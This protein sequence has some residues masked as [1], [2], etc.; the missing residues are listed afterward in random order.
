MR[1]ER[2]HLLPDL[3]FHD[4][5]LFAGMDFPVVAHLTPVGDVGQQLMQAAFG[6]GSAPAHVALAREALLVAPAP[7]RQLLDDGKQTPVLQIQGKN[8]PHPRRLRVVDH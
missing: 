2:L 7:P 8:G 1:Q 4:G 3:S 6:E 5:W